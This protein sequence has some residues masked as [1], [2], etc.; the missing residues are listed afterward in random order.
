MVGEVERV[1][2]ALDW[3][4]S[5]SR[6]WGSD[7][8]CVTGADGSRARSEIDVSCSRCV[9]A[10][11]GFGVGSA[12]GGAGLGVAGAEKVSSVCQLK[13]GL[14]GWKRTREEALRAREVGF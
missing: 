8:C 9:I 4:L 7:H 5:A 13:K 2:R 3:Y 11:A 12:A 14:A 1:R 10:D 6:K